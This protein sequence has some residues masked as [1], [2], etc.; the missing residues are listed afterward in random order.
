MTDTRKP[1]RDEEGVEPL[2]RRIADLPRAQDRIAARR[3]L[4]WLAP[5]A[6]AFALIVLL[7]P[8]AL[9]ADMFRRLRGKEIAARR[10]G[11][12]PTGDVHWAHV[13]E[14]GGRLMSMS[15]GRSGNG[16]GRVPPRRRAVSAAP[17]AV[18]ACTT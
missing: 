2:S 18:V 5:A 8:G 10:T 11:M 9:A 1:S 7:A 16:T 6:A 3:T 12:K 4:L 17:A 14:S 15:M 13:F